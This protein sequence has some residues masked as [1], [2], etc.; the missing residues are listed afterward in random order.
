MGHVLCDD[1]YNKGRDEEIEVPSGT[2]DRGSFR[3]KRRRFL[4]GQDIEILSGI[5]VWFLL[6]QE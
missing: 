2:K 1:S 3:E 5:R 4:P 6:E